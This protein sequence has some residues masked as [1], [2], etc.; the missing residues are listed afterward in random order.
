MR[1]SDLASIVELSQAALCSA[2]LDH[3]RMTRPDEAELLHRL[4]WTAARCALAGHVTCDLHVTPTLAP[5][6]EETMTV[7]EII[8]A[9]RMGPLLGLQEPAREP[10]QDGAVA[11]VNGRPEEG[12][13]GLAKA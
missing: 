8:A 5:R 13:N 2:I 7:E 12:G 9:L 1:P 3:L 11:P 6:G 10:A 4:A